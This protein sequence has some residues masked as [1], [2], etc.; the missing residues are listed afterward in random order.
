[1]R[2]LLVLLIPF[3]TIAS[4]GVE[5]AHSPP[6]S[7]IGQKASNPGG[8]DGHVT[9]GAAGGTWRA[10]QVWPGRPLIPASYIPLVWGGK[11]WVATEHSHGGQPSLACKDGEITLAC[12]NPWPGQPGEKLAALVFEAPSAGRYVVSASLEAFAWDD[13]LPAW[14]RVI[15]LPARGDDKKES[16]IDLKWIELVGLKNRARETIDNLTVNLE[17]GDRLVFVPKLPRGFRGVSVTL[18]NLRIIG[19]DRT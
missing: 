9:K 12:R 4:A 19:T 18:R 17:S 8:P 2:P 3:L 5:S 14:L 1:V 13:G 15:R 11:S 6:E 7:W 10:M 16:G